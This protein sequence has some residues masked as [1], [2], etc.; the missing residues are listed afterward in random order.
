[1]RKLPNDRAEQRRR[2]DEDQIARSAGQASRVTSYRRMPAATA[3][4][5]DSTPGASGI[6]TRRRAAARERGAHAGAFVAQHQRD[7]A[8]AR[9][10]RRARSSGSPSAAATQSSTPRS[11]RPGEELVRVGRDGRQPERG[12]HA[13]A[14]HLGVGQLGRAL[15]RHHARRAE[16]RARSGA[17]CRRCR[18]PAPRRAPA[19]APPGAG[20][21]RPASSARGSIT[22]TTPCG[23][24]VSASV[25][26]LGGRS[27]PPARTPA[28]PSALLSACP[29][30]VPSSA[31]ETAAPRTGTPAASA[32]STSRT[33]SA[34]ASPRRSRPRR[35]AGRGSWSAAE[36]PMEVLTG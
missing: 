4:L 16:R 7:A 5:S 34:S 22:A 27:P 11:A 13:A 12:A 2:S 8:A 30:G 20:G 21:C 9:A 25:V 19:T 32:S 35:R 15:E 24:S 3:T 26:E 33:P 31:G 18:G 1:M 29:R 36:P 23:C 17:W 14:Q 10:A 6:A 28:P